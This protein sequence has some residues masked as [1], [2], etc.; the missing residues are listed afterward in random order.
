MEQHPRTEED[1][2]DMV[3][4]QEQQRL[5]W[6]LI[7]SLPLI[8]QQIML[9]RHQYRLS[10]A[11]IAQEL[12]MTEAAVKQRHHRAQQVLRARLSQFEDWTGLPDQ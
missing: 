8:D 2:L 9:L 3:L 5:G 12:N 11:Q 1:A 4:R 10:H 7:R 6:Q